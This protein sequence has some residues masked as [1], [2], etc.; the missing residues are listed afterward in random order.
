MR[1]PAMGTEVH[2]LVPAGSAS[3]VGEVESLFATWEARLTRFRPDSELMR[4]NASAGMPTVVSPL[5]FRVVVAAIDGAAETGGAF[6]PTLL[7]DQVRI[8]YDRSFDAMAASVPPDAGSPGRGGAWRYVRLDAKARIVDLPT[9]C[10]LDLGGIAKGMAVD[11]ALELLDD[12]GVSSSLVSAGGD[13]AVRGR[14]PGHG[15]WQVLVGSDGGQIVSLERGALATSGV[16]RRSWRQGTVLRHHLLDPTTGEPADSGVREVTVAAATCAQAE[17]AA[18][19]AFVRGPVHGADVLRRHRL[20]GRLT[21][22]DGSRI[23]VEPWPAR[24]SEAA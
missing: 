6:D 1:F 12:L 11:A 18:T 20:A 10:A 23:F 4:L 24:R 9:G 5:L 7:R 19:A 16:A 8:G 2:V 15:S 22:V 17:V 14:P 3:V 21:L 13:L